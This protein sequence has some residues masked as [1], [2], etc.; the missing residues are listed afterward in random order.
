MGAMTYIGNAPNF[1]VKAIAEERGV[2]M[3]SFGGYLL[4][5]GAV[6]LPL[7]PDGLDMDVKP[8]CSCRRRAP[9]EVW[10]SLPPTSTWTP[11]DGD[12]PLTP[13][14][15]R[16][17]LQARPAPSSPA[18]SAS[19]AELLD[20]CPGCASSARWRGLQQH[21]PAACTARGVLVTNT[22][23]VLTETT[24]DFGFALLMAT[25]RRMAE[26]ERPARGG[27][28]S[29]SWDFLAGAEVHGSTLGILGMGRIGQAIARRGR[30]A[31][32]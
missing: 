5:S 16:A 1:M 3:P 14:E 20:A 11:R 2:R 19:T 26:G 15:L 17:R 23:D 27:W 12:E 4:W 7:F 29:W 31:S 6:M 21:R 32:A 30:S 28:K 10:T 18:P 22:P 9:A 25:A 24:A 8:K 13:A